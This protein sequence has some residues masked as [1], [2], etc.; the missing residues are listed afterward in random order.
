MDCGATCLRIICKYFGVVISTTKLR[1]LCF[2]T[3]RGVNM[4]GIAEAAEELGLEPE[5]SQLSVDKLDQV[6]LPAILHWK[7]NHFVVLYKIQ[8]EK[9]YISDPANKL[10]KYSREDFENNWYPSTEIGKGVLIS[11]SIPT[12]S[13]HNFGKSNSEN[14]WKNIL[15]YFSGHTNLFIQ[16]FIGLILSG[17]FELSIP[18]L[19]QNAVDLG[20]NQKNIDFLYFVLFS[21]LLFFIGQISISAFR[22]WTLLHISTRVN[23]EILTDFLIKLMKLPFSFFDKRTSGDILQRMEDQQRIEEFITK[24]FL[25]AIYSI[26]HVMI[27]GSILYF[28]SVRIFIV[29]FVCTIL[30]I[31]WILIFMRS[32]KEIDIRQFDLSSLNSTYTVEMIQSIRDIKLNNAEQQI[33][34]IWEDIQARIFK[35]KEKSLFVFQAQSIGSTAINSIR[36]ILITFLSARAVIDGDI[37]IGAMMAVQYITGS[38][39]TPIKNVLGLIQS[40][41][42]ASLSVE[43]LNEIY[44]AGEERVSVD[45]YTEIIPSNAFIRF[46]N[47]TFK[48]FGSGNRPIFTN[49][50]MH[51]PAGK[52]TAIVGE[53]G[54]GKTT[55]LKLILRFYDLQ[56]GIIKVG[57]CNLERIDFKIWRDACGCVLQ[58]NIIFSNTI[59]ENISIGSDQIDYERL[60]EAIKIACLDDFIN[61]QPFGLKTKIGNAGK[62][63]SQGQKQR[64]LIARA[65]Y[66]QPKFIFL[67]EAT[68]ALD[69]KNEKN[70]IN[71]LSSFFKNRTVIVV[72]HR[73]ST[74]KNADNIIVMEKGAIIEQGTHL[75]LV[76]KKATYFHLI[77]N[78]LELS[79]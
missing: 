2:T 19:T 28:Y 44:E 43:R 40:Y 31:I 55:I 41:Q 46:E 27:F 16:L 25:D 35:L 1:D 74:V 24:S 38:I 12:R 9:F 57:N 34:L 53:S 7:Q 69:A 6:G 50:N 29:F 68:N 64:I 65:V 72:A 17:I 70:I 15:R 73:L 5:A 3:N 59:E 67:D 32:R 56:A 54:S 77:K 8:N 61:E 66:K 51:F 75:Q 23:I 22:S 20:I 42:D 26:I 13:K 63:I 49:L 18:F 11:L 21:Q 48:Y 45:N 71:N 76:A 47:V 39:D 58:D 79:E 52:T 10:I 37:T 62:G 78:Q 60:N 33:R 36:T 4:L 14:K 30:Y